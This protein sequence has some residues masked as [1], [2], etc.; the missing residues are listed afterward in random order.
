MT[1]VKH[2]TKPDSQ[3]TGDL[4]AQIATLHALAIPNIGRGK[5]SAASFK[6]GAAPQVEHFA[7]GDVA[8]HVA[9]IRR[10]GADPGRNAFVPLAI[11]RPDLPN[12]RKGG[13]ADI[14][15]VLGVVGDFDDADAG[16]WAERLPCPPDYVLETSAGRFQCG[17]FFDH[18]LPVAEAKTIGRALRDSAR[19]DHGALDASHVWRLPETVNWPTAAKLAAGRSPLPQPVRVV[20]PWAGTVTAVDDLRRI[21]DASTSPHAAATTT[22]EADAWNTSPLPGWDDRWA[23]DVA[24][25]AHLCEKPASPRE[26]F[27]GKPHFRH[28]VAA[29]TSGSY[30]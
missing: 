2:Y 11:L 3:A 15:A 1:C 6:D 7:I 5:L 22:P 14:V 8:G 24:L 9:A 12:G 27:N 28:Y 16:R 26:A 4:D 29:T 25:I 20:K 19:C 21:L 23:D 17:Y 10:M 18:P 30:P 13:E